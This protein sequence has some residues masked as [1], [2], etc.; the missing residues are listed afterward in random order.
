MMVGLVIKAD[1]SPGDASAHGGQTGEYLDV[2][3]TSRN[4]GTEGGTCVYINKDCK[5]YRV[6][7]S[8]YLKAVTAR[9]TITCTAGTV[10]THWNEHCFYKVL[11]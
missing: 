1:G 11:N 8:N 3:Y 4:S 5:L 7:Y 6:C 2:Y 10:Y 9:E